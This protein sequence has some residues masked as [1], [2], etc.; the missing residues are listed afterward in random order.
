M[1]F[2]LNFLAFSPPL[3]SHDADWFPLVE[4]Y[5]NMIINDWM[6]VSFP[7]LYGPVYKVRIPVIIVNTQGH[8]NNIKGLNW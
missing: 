7:R 4:L 6:I 3:R 5:Y 1:L 2:F 8:T